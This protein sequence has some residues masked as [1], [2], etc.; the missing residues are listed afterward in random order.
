MKQRI[1][2][3]FKI[4]LSSIIS[5]FFFHQNDQRFSLVISLLYLFLFELQNQLVT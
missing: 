2:E 4:Y 3:E 1:Q 5:F